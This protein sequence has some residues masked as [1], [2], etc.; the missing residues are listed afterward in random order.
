MKRRDRRGG[1]ANRYETM[2][3]RFS[4]VDQRIEEIR[5]TQQVSKEEN[6]VALEGERCTNSLMRSWQALLRKQ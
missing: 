6:D 2:F 4:T 3:L 5:G 1:I